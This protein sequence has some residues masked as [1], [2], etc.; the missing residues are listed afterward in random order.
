M[1]NKRTIAMMI[2]MLI[3]VS[4]TSM[5]TFSITT[6]GSSNKCPPDKKTCDTHMGAGITV[7]QACDDAVR[8][9]KALCEGRSSQVKS[10]CQKYCEKG[11]TYKGKEYTCEA[12]SMKCDDCSI[13]KE[14]EW[15]EDNKKWVCKATCCGTC[16]C[17]NPKPK[18]SDSPAEVSPSLDSMNDK[19]GWKMFLERLF[20]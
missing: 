15:D 5:G 14:P 4:V 16:S 9:A 3:I 12:S 1:V 19:T 10:K 20:K 13:T 18:R 7:T 6:G 17:R 11:Q 8:K 2:G